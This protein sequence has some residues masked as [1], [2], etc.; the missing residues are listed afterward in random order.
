MNEENETLIFS[1][2]QIHLLCTLKLRDKTVLNAV[3][4]LK[5]IR[6]KNSVRQIFAQLNINLLC[7][8]FDSLTHMVRDTID[9]LL[10]SETKTDSSFPSAQFHIE[11]FTISSRDRNANGGG[12]LLFVPEDIPSACSDKATEGLYDEINIRK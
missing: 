6:Q 2:D 4:E 11:G 10:I 8:K 12:I 1:T 9:V 5:N 7:N 3:H